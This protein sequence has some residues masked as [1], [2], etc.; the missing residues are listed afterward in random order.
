MY[1]PA[2][3]SQTD[4]AALQ[5]LIA[6]HPL[7]M[8]VTSND[9][10]PDADHLPFELVAGNGA[11]TDA[12]AAHGILRAHVARGN[13]VW[14]RAGQRVLAVFRGPSGYVTPDRIEKA[15]TGGRVVPTWVYDVV[16]VHGVLRAVDNAAWLRALVTRQTEHQEAIQPDPWSVDDAPPAYIEAM[17]KAIVGIEIVVE[18][19][20]GKWKREPAPRVR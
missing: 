3:F 5:A 8:L 20:E 2:R 9:G 11:D 19:M 10:L 14:R 12:P 15:E 4:P 6:A 17:L 18:R 7:G 1:C 13:P 16:H